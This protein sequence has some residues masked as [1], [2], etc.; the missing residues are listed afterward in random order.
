MGKSTA[1][2]RWQDDSDVLITCDLRAV[3]L[4]GLD[5][6]G[7]ADLQSQPVHPRW[8]GLGRFATLAPATSALSA[9]TGSASSS[10]GGGARRRERA[11][12][13]RRD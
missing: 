8:P 13:G 4:D 2:T 1:A 12:V 10:V 3:V 11:D 7:A 6:G 9:P 5:G